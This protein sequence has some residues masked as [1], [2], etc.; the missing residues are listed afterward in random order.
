MYELLK[1]LCEVHSPSGDE[2]NMKEFILNFVH[3]HAHMWKKKP[4][5]FHGAEFQD[6]LVLVFGKPD[7]A[8][9]AHMDTTGFS[10][11]YQHQLIPIG[12]PEVGGGELLTGSDELGQIECTLSLNEEGQ[13]HYDFGRGITSGASLIFRPDFH[14]DHSFVQSPY[15]DNRVGIYNLLKIAEQLENGAL[16]FTCWEEHGGGSVPFLVKFLYERFG[17]SKMLVSDITWISDGIH[18]DGGV[19]ISNRD[20]LIPRRS[21]VKNVLALAQRSGISYQV[22]VE[23][24]GSSDGREIQASPYPIDWCFIGA[25]VKYAHSNHEKISKKDLES[26]IEFYQILMDIL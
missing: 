7:T 21:F 16:V 3:A 23:A 24:H 17:I 12:G 22:E 20:Q 18:F 10:V 19:V 14:V 25:P 1:S 9:L 15:L 6:C 8:A 26:M 13:L 4:Q 5:V 11:R 2:A